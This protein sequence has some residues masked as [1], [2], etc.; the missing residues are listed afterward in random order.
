MTADT[1]TEP[2]QGAERAP[3]A[4]GRPSLYQ[5]A[6]AEQAFK[7][8]LLM[9]ATDKDLADFFEV[10][11]ATINN[12]KLDFPEFATQLRA[13]KTQADMHIA[14]KLFNRAEG[15]RWT[16]EVAHKVKTEHF[17]DLG[18]K[19]RTEEHIETVEITKGAPPDTTAA[20]FWLKN[21]DPKRWRD[22]QELQHTG[23]DG[24]ALPEAQVLAGLPGEVLI[25]LLAINGKL[26]SGAEDGADQSGDHPT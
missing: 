4:G 7:L 8:C 1:P 9:G 10:C 5:P 17:D 21:R 2:V 20:I 11:E 15:A 6:Y 26:A 22:K 25:E 13:G 18:K 12:W 19:L 23:K 16:E 3:H 14:S 24:E